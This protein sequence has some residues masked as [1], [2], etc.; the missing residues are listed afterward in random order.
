MK[1]INTVKEMVA[2]YL[3]KNGFDG[4]FTYECGC[5]IT[6][7]FPCGNPGCIDCKPGYISR[8]DNDFSIGPKKLN[9]R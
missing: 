4:L 7:L 8:I 6:D 2:E 5:E 9:G 3:G 1:K